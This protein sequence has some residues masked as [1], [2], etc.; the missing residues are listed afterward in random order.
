[1]SHPN[2]PFGI[3]ATPTPLGASWTTSTRT[4]NCNGD[5]PIFRHSAPRS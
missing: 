4:P 2:D 3:H 1:M 5:S